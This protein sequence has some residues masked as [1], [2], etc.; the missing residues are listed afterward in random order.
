MVKLKRVLILGVV[1]SLL[2]VVA[3]SG[4]SVA[5]PNHTVLKKP[6]PPGKVL[7]KGKCVKKR[8][9]GPTVP[10][11][12]YACNL[13]PGGWGAYGVLKIVPGNRYRVNDGKPGRYVYGPRAKVLTFKTGD[14]VGFFGVYSKNTI[15]IR[16]AE[17]NEYVTKGDWLWSCGK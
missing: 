7:R 5:E 3:W 13:S 2:G 12:T 16:A 6:C 15:E 10:A 11:G 17:S 9:S 14:Y 1:G 4:S 8:R